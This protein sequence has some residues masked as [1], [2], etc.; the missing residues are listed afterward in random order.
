VV[1]ADLSAVQA[2]LAGRASGSASQHVADRLVT[3]PA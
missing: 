3:V 2:H 1:V